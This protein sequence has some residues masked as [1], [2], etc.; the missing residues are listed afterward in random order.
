MSRTA[1]SASL[2]LLVVSLLAPR[3]CLAQP[4]V[5]NVVDN[6]A[7]FRIMTRPSINDNGTVAFLAATG[8]VGPPPSTVRAF[9]YR[10]KSDGTLCSVEIRVADATTPLRVAVDN[11]GTA[12]FLGS[13]LLRVAPDGTI[14]RL[15]DKA[16]PFSGFG[17]FASPPAG[18][19]APVVFSALLDNTFSSGIYNGPDPVANRL[20]NPSLQPSAEL[21]G[22]GPDGSPRFRAAKPTGGDRNQ[23][24]KGP[25]PQ[26]DLVLDLSNFSD[27]SQYTENARG[28]VL[29]AASHNGIFGLYNGPD[30]LANR[31][32]DTTTTLWGMSGFLNDNGQMVI[33]GQAGAG[34]IPAL[35]AGTNPA[36]DRILGVGDPLFGST[37]QSIGFDLADQEAFN[38]RGE[39]AFGYT[40]ADGHTGIAVVT[41]PEPATLAALSLCALPIIGA[42]R[43]W[44]SGAAGRT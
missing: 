41:V 28:D 33:F 7:P 37:L 24:Y 31:V 3:L 39:L 26:T 2:P 34:A 5:R 1:L 44:T 40:L 32:A 16:G 27:I 21:L 17:S 8:Q 12:T 20:D 29:F 36:T 4:Q 30:P 13:A 6:T 10:A 15:A 22:M 19:A 23:I 35:Y 25:N 18:S 11:T 14:S 42:R 9:V 43:R 38:N